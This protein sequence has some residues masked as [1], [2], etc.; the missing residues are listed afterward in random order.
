MVRRRSRPNPP[1]WAESEDPIGAY[2]DEFDE[3]PD[4]DT[5]QLVFNAQAEADP[6]FGSRRIEFP[7]GRVVYVSWSGKPKTSMYGKTAPEYV[8]PVSRADGSIARED[9]NDY[10]LDI[11]SNGDYDG[12]YDDACDRFHDE[13]WGHP[14]VLLHGSRD[15]DGVMRDGLEARQET[16]GISNRHVGRAIFST[17]HL[18]TAESYAG[19]RRRSSRDA[20]GIVEIDTAAM[21]RDGLTPRVQMEPDYCY[22]DT[23]GAIASTLGIDYEPEAEQGIDP[24]TVIIFTPVIPPKYLRRHSPRRDNPPGRR[25]RAVRA[26]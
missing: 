23:I 6:T 1:A 5:L 13:F 11:E 9:P 25:R 14:P 26:R 4:E 21:K 3:F 16:T 19:S 7:L 10:I 24:E 20:G 22:A 15:V 17:T 8:Y 12:F 18:E 2:L